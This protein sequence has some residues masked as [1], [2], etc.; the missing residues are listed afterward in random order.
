MKRAI[1]WTSLACLFQSFQMFF[2]ESVG[3]YQNSCTIIHTQTS[4]AVISEQ[5]TMPL[6][7]NNCCQFITASCSKQPESRQN[8]LRFNKLTACAGGT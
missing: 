3:I 4:K 2:V 1:R 6:N 8:S 7:S 5:A